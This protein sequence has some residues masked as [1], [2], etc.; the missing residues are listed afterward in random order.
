MHV[1]VCICTRN[2]GASIVATLRSVAALDY[3]DF[4]V[5]ILDQSARDDT[6]RA[7]RPT[8]AGD[9]RFRYHRSRTRGLSTAR[10]LLVAQA[11]GPIVAFTDD[12]CVVA[13][14]WL[15]HLVAAFRANPDVGE[16]CGPVVAAPYDETAGFVP[17]SEIT[18]VRRI[19]TRWLAWRDCGIGANMAFRL[20]ALRRVGPFDEVL[21]AGAPLYS[22]ED[23]DMT[24]R[25]LRAG[26]SVLDLPGLSVV[27]SGFRSWE[28]GTRHMREA[29]ISVGA[30]YLKHLRL[31]DLAVLP[32]LAHY[33]LRA[34]RWDRLLTLRSRSGLRFVLACLWGMRLSFDY[35]I[36][37]GNR[38]YV[39][40]GTTA[41]VSRPA[42][43]LLADLGAYRT[44]AASMPAAA[45]SSRRVAGAGRT[46]LPRTTLPYVPARRGATLPPS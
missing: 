6:E 34:V 10:N 16:I 31:G 32:T 40:S 13:P 25:M 14:G 28:V 45:S 36:A 22:G 26:F 33:M 24:Y 20:N 37:L 7:I 44:A 4:D 41:G 29:G 38:T 43:T 30:C 2:R 9:A 46:I 15:S 23:I 27:H 18:T 1:T 5:V 42:G 21:S 3:P 12:D 35:A 8:V 19:T 39:G 11:R 17:T